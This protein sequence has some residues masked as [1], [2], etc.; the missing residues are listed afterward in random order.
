MDAI[1]A[2]FPEEGI[3]AT[4]ELSLRV[5]VA[6]LTKV[7]FKHPEYGRTM[8]ALE[9]TATLC[10]IEGRQEVIVKAKPFNGRMRIKDLEGFQ[11]FIGEFHFDSQRLREE[12]DFRI[13]IRPQDWERVKAFYLQQFQEESSV[14]ESRPE[15]LGFTTCLRF[16]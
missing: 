1:N 6:T 13:H 2:G 9:R 10:E 8:L 4:A 7:L 15:Q 3:G 5:S 14:L 11:T 12:M 16:D